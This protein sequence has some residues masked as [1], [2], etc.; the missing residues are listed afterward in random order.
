MPPHAA[1]LIVAH[2]MIPGH[3]QCIGHFPLLFDWE[4]NVALNAKNKRRRV[5][6]GPKSFCKFR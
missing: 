5:C 2:C 3:A 4:E 6:Q 1:K